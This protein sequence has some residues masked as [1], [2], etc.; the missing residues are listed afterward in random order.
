MFYCDHCMLSLCALLFFQETIFKNLH[1][2]RHLL[3]II[4]I[5]LC[6]SGQ[7]GAVECTAASRRYTRQQGK[8]VRTSVLVCPQRAEKRD[9]ITS[10]H[11]GRVSGCPLVIGSLRTDVKT[12]RENRDS[13]AETFS[14]SDRDGAGLGKSRGTARAGDAGL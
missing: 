13:A 14:E 2:S 5:L 12:K 7:P 4:I 1:F 3:L 8:W 10:G 11:R 6:F 9:P